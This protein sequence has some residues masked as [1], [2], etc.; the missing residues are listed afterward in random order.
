MGGDPTTLAYPGIFLWL[1]VNK[2]QLFSPRQMQPP[3]VCLCNKHTQLVDPDI[4]RE[5]KG[6]V[7]AFTSGLLT[8]NKHPAHQAPPWPNPTLLLVPFEKQA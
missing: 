2:I 5:Q 8:S 1:S 4:P 3:S 7:N 6:E